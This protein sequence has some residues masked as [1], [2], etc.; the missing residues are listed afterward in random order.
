MK[1]K[2]WYCSFLK[3]GIWFPLH[4]WILSW[5][6]SLKIGKHFVGFLYIW[7]LKIG[8]FFFCKYG[9]W[10]SW[11]LSWKFGFGFGFGGGGVN[12]GNIKFCRF[13]QQHTRCSPTNG[14][15]EVVCFRNIGTKCYKFGKY[16]LLFMFLQNFC[17]ACVYIYLMMFRE[18]LS[19]TRSI[20]RSNEE[21]SFNCAKEDWYCQQGV[22][23]SRTDLPEEG[24]KHIICHCILAFTLTMFVCPIAYMLCFFPIVDQS[25]PVCTHLD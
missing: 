10:F 17:N 9:V 18:I 13:I 20:S 12:C 2:V 22:K 23:T 7:R 24:I 5:K 16:E 19:G 1:I 11:I 8:V 21:R 15:W 3:Y 4:C 6:F 14:V 25:M